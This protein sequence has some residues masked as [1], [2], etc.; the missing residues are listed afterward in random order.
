[1]KRFINII[2]TLAAAV[3]LAVSCQKDE[4]SL[5]KALVGTW[6]LDA[7]IV[8]GTELNANVNVY[9]VLNS[10][11][12]FALYQRTGSQDKRYDLYTGDCNAENG[13]LTGTYSN[14]TPWGSS[15][16]Y[17]VSGSTLT[18][19][20]A[21]GMEEQVYVKGNLPSDITVN[22]DTKSTESQTPIL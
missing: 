20:S 11:K 13:V 2:M 18:L 7:T 3:C 5:D 19:K 12:T 4:T 17:K 22:P 1:M 8:D 14:G 9:L 21:D 10:D 6:H 15:Y 16:K